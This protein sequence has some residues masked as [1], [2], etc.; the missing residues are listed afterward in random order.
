MSDKEGVC[1]SF[2]VYDAALFHLLEVIVE[3]RDLWEIQRTIA[4]VRIVGGYFHNIE[5]DEE[6]TWEIMRRMLIVGE[7]AVSEL[8]KMMVDAEDLENGFYSWLY[9]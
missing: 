4:L 1:A 9:D 6:A 5:F 8:Q 3:V 7:A 2:A